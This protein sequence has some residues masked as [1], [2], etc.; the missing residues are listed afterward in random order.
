MGTSFS[1]DME[2]HAVPND[3]TQ[4]V[5]NFTVTG[6]TGRFAGGDGKLHSG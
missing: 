1:L 5:A 3:L 2:G 6:G 4:T